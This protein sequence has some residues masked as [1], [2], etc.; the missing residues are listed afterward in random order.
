M[1]QIKLKIT[2]TS[3]NKDNKLL[4]INSI[5]PACLSE[6]KRISRWEFLLDQIQVEM[7]GTLKMEVT[8]RK[9]PNIWNFSGFIMKRQKKSILI[10]SHLKLQWLCHYYG[11]RK[12][13]L[14]KLPPKLIQ[15]HQEGQINQWLQRML[16]EWS[17]KSYQNNRLMSCG[18]SC[19]KNQKISGKK[20]VTLTALFQRNHQMWV[21][22]RSAKTQPL[23]TTIWELCFRTFDLISC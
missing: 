21:P 1:G 6:I 13:T 10:G 15:Q 22:W 7:K 20:K 9:I 12:K 2:N 17:I 4:S 23:F 16:S 5:T 19:R 3:K 14:R 11:K 8:L 18:L